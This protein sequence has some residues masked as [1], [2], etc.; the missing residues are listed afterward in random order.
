MEDGDSKSEN[1]SKIVSFYRYMPREKLDDLD[2]E[3]TRLSKSKDPLIGDELHDSV[4]AVL[5]KKGPL[6]LQ[7][8]K[9]IN[10]KL[11][12]INDTFHILNC[13]LQLSSHLQRHR[14]HQPA[15]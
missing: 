4:L 11:N 14:R 2:T 12:P 3:R 6:F 13:N 5:L 8:R 15:E 9:T 10:L 1:I 7:Y